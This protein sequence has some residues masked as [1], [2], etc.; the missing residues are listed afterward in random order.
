MMD[1]NI[2]VKSNRAYKT[3][4]ELCGRYLQPYFATE[5]VDD[6]AKVKNVLQLLNYLNWNCSFTYDGWNLIESTVGWDF[7]FE[8]IMKHDWTPSY[9]EM[10]ENAPEPESFTPTS[11]DLEGL[12]RSDED[13]MPHA[14]IYLIIIEYL[15]N[16]VV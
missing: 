12:Y 7:A 8:V 15:S 5:R 4:L 6:P 14:E 10:Y 9:Q 13:E 2:N 11:E 16:Q 3:A 1:E